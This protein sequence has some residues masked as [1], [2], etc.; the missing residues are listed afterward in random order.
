MMSDT[1]STI[2][3]EHP[4]NEKMRAWLRIESSLQQLTSQRHLDSLA[5]S[6]AFFRTVTELLEVLERGEV[7]SELLKEL[8]RQ[9][10]KLKQ[11]AEIPDVDINIVNS[12][13]LKL[14]ERATALSKAPRWDNP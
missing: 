6:L 13:R 1:T 10:A 7:R 3:F 2:I 12:F 11:W 14:K 4:L 9:Q 5:S 8:E